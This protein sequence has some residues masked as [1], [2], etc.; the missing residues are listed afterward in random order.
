ML[1]GAINAVSG[2]QP[3]LLPRPFDD[4]LQLLGFGKDGNL[5]SAGFVNTAAFYFFLTYQS[6]RVLPS[7]PVF[8]HGL[9][10]ALAL[11]TLF[12]IWHAIFIINSWVSRGKLSQGFAIAMSF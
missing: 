7:Y 5:K 12:S 3:S 10:P 2:L 6:L 1:F 11:A 4:L 8:L 9:D